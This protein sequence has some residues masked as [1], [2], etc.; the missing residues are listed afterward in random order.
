MSGFCQVEMSPFGGSGTSLKSPFGAPEAGHGLHIKGDDDNARTGAV[1]VCSRGCG[2]T[3]EA[4]PGCRAVGSDHT[5]GAA[6]GA[7]L[8]PGRSCGSDFQA[9]QSTE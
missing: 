1:E 8:Q 5:S 6:T 3:T 4:L 2:P 9:P 7:P